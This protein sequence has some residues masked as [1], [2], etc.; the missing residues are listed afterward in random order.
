MVFLAPFAA[1]GYPVPVG[2]DVP[3]Y[4]WWARVGAAEGLSAIGTRPGAPALIPTVAR[5]IG[6]GSLTSVAGLQ[7]ALGPAIGLAGAALIL[8]RDRAPRLVWALGGLFTG[9]W[10]VH[11][12][13]GYLAN[14]AFVACFIAAA[15]AL[16]RRTRRGAALAA[17]LLAGGGLAH[18][19]FFVVG[20]GIL[21]LAAGWSVWFDRED[22]SLGWRTDAGRTFAALGASAVVVGGGLLAMLAGPAALGGDTS[23]DAFLRRIGEWETLG[24]TYLDRFFRNPGRYAPWV[25][26]PLAGLGAW[27]GVGGAGD[28]SAVVR[29]GA[30][31]GF[32]RRFLLAWGALT[33]VA[34]PFAIVT[35]WFP[36]DRM[37]TF[38]FCVPLLAAVGLVWVCRRIPR[39]GLAAAAGIA[40]VVAFA[41]PSLASWADQRGFLGPQELADTATAGRIAATLPDGT[42]LVYVVDE[43]ANSSIFAASHAL[44]MA[45]A[46]VPPDRADDVRVYVG[47]A[48][49][50]LDGE[51]TVRANR[52]FTLASRTSLADIPS[53]APKAVFVI[54]DLARGERSFD[55]PRLVRWSVGLATTEPGPRPLAPVPGEPGISSPLAMSLAALA[56]FVLLAAIGYGWARWGIGGAGAA[57]LAAPACGVAILTVVAVAAERLG[58]PLDASASTFVLSA[59]AGGSGYVLVALRGPAVPAGEGDAALGEGEAE[60]SAP[61][62]VP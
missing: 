42:L 33:V 39:R 56:T 35:R 10:A 5:V 22:G 43:P 18:P 34:V 32:V 30:R 55:D 31:G 26:V 28:T 6:V 17:L 21:A 45:R 44:N 38:A 12:G 57:L 2:P 61:T 48:S 54:A 27:R 53:G 9:I 16:A 25:S 51:P 49:R 62:H 15:A 23:K 1:T 3:V 24:R 37:L 14:L 47:D 46:T 40:F 20:A 52:L 60:V 8:G 11:L 13:A 4:L 36:P 19:Q 7:Y 29:V 41:W 50:L 58:V 59:L